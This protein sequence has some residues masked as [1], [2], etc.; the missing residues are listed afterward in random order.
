MDYLNLPMN[1]QEQYTKIIEDTEEIIK[2]FKEITE[3][4]VSR[5]DK[6][7]NTLFK[8]GKNLVSEQN[9]TLDENPVLGNTQ[10]KFLL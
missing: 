6:K 4:M 9:E 5:I 3:L 7:N 2:N 10:I 8:L 1:K